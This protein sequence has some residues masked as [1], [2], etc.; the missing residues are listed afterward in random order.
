MQYKL[1]QLAVPNTLERCLLCD[2]S[3]LERL[4]FF[5]GWDEERVQ[6]LTLLWARDDADADYILQAN[7]VS[8]MKV[9]IASGNLS[10]AR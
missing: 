7:T 1:N 8:R 5:E 2:N 6:I 4:E 10:Q 3:T 9:V